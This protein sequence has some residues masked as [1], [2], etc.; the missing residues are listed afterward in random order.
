[1][2]A[3]SAVW[4]S[5]AVWCGAKKSPNT[6][7]RVGTPT[8][9]TDTGTLLSQ[10]VQSKLPGVCRL[11]GIAASADRT[12]HGLVREAEHILAARLRE[13]HGER[14]AGTGAVVRQQAVAG[15]DR[16]EHHA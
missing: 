13:P 16:H 2:C 4:R 12:Q 11:A 9:H 8:Q 14:A 5:S 7:I 6:K 10:C 15:E 1:M 3:V